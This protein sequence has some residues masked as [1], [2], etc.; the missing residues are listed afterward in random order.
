MPTPVIGMVGIIDEVENCLGISAENNNTLIILGQKQN[1]T[2]GWLGCSLYQEIISD[3]LDGTPPPID[4]KIEKQIIETIITLN[5]NKLLTGAHDIS[6]GGLLTATCE[7][8]FENRLGLNVNLPKG[9]LSSDAKDHLLHSWCFGED[10]NR[11]IVSTNELDKVV[12]LLKENLIDYYILGTTN[13]SSNLN[14][15]ELDTI[16]LME[17]YNINESTIP[18]LMDTYKS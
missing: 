10:Q 1:F 13:T 11:I 8:L 3:V 5:N 2:E 17:L 14:L 18:S 6:D 9:L 16:S 12:S 15:N 4:L 7:M